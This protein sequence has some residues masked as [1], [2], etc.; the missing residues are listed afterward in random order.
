MTDI[1]ILSAFIALP[2]LAA[3]VCWI[4]PDRPGL[5]K[6]VSVGFSAVLLAASIAVLCAAI[7]SHRAGFLLREKVAVL[8][9]WGVSWHLGVDG[10][11][12][13]LVFL[14]AL[15]QTVATLAAA[16][17]G[18]ARA[19]HALVHLLVAGVYRSCRA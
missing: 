16:P 13:A 1:A 6:A 17:A 14:T 12:A 3:L 2:L 10:L 4:L 7:G 15:I 18:R 5:Q 9:E 19:Y 11:S 8:P